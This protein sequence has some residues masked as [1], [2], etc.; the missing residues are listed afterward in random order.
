MAGIGGIACDFVKGNIR[1]LKTRVTAYQQ[2]GFGGWGAHVVGRGD[3]SFAFTAVLYERSGPIET[4]A[5][6]IES[7]Q[8]TIISIVDD[9]GVT[10]F[11]CLVMRVGQPTKTTAIRPQDP[12]TS[13]A[14]GQIDVMGVI[15]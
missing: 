10:Y 14:R 9:F 2:T 1:D 5:R 8:G 13:G 12:V 15:V 3:S 7:L 11:N 4:W 6:A